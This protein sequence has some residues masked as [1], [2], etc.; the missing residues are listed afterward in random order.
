MISSALRTIPAGS[1]AEPG[2]PM[3]LM[4]IIITTCVRPGWLSTSRSKRASALTPAPSLSTRLPLMPSLRTATV[5]PASLS[6]RASTSGQ[7]LLV[8][9]LELE[10]SVIE[11]PNATI[12]RAGAPGS[13]ITP[14]RKNRL[15][16]LSTAGNSELAVKSPAPETKAVC[17]PT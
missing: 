2:K 9:T 13:T 5:A 16:K 11:S 14:L 12:A 3:S 7:R 15:A 17:R 6:R 1:I 10:P 8:L 4:P